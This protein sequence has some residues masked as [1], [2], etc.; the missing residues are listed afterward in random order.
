MSKPTIEIQQLGKRYALGQRG[1]LDRT[2]CET[3]NGMAGKLLGRSAPQLDTQVSDAADAFWALRDVSFD[4]NPG[5]VVGIIGSNGAGKSTLLKVLSRITPPTTGS[6]ALRGRVASLLE[7][8]TGFHPE[9][10]GRENIYLN[11]A[12]LGMRRKEVRAKFNDIV[13]F[14]G[15]EKFLD[16]PVKRYSSG[17]RVRL[18]FAVA[19][20]LEPEI[21]I[22]D[23]VLAVGDAAFQKRCLGKM[24]Q[25][26][27]GAGRT[28]L[29]V[30][31]NAKAIRNLCSRV[32]WLEGG[33]LRAVGETEP[34]LG[35]YMQ[36][37]GTTASVD[38]LPKAIASLP[39]DPDF[40]LRDVRITQAG[41]VCQTF[42]ADLPVDIEIRYEVK[43]AAE[44]LRVFFDLCDEYEDVLI[45]SFHDERAAEVVT[46]QPGA[47]VAHAQIP[48]HLLAARGYML[49]IQAGI[50]NVRKCIPG[51]LRVPLQVV[52]ASDLNRA[53]PAEA[54]RSKLQPHIAWT[55]NQIAGQQGRAAA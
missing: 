41:Q 17:M 2:L 28:V 55:H 26:A 31:H 32:A 39:A 52:A 33:T 6:V 48:A 12:V 35:E 47:Y 1:A 38:D 43:R 8:G 50:F 5:E 14:S 15:V 4:V 18:A 22:I 54:G 24:Q 42:A 7:V 16:T 46:M 40:A 29:F 36:S 27:D 9:L 21:L 30:S 44:G 53:Y 25:L 3:L 51:S 19:A 10:T 11:G 34:V 37:T 20:H 49:G 13:E 45:R 23:E